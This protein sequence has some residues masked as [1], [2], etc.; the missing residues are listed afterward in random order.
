M[1]ERAFPIQPRPDDDPRFTLG[2]ILEVAEVLAKHG[3]PDITT[4]D[5]ARDFVEFRQ[6]LFGFLYVGEWAASP[7]A[8]TLA[9][10]V[11]DNTKETHDGH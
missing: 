5:R 7:G 11:P 3:Y 6:A 8:D 1:T 9:A 10:P 2:L 4:P